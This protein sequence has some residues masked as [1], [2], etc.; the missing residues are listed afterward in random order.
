MLFQNITFLAVRKPKKPGFSN[1]TNAY[2]KN[3][4]VGYVGYVGATASPASPLTI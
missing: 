3:S 1:N 4:L 2:L